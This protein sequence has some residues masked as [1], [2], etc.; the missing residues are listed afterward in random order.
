MNHHP[1][2]P[3]Q[4]WELHL[5]E[6]R[7]GGLMERRTAEYLSPAV[8]RCSLTVRAP[9]GSTLAANISDVP[10]LRLALPVGAWRADW[11]SSDWG[12]EFH[13]RQAALTDGPLHLDV[14]VGRSSKTLHPWLCLTSPEHGAVIISPA[15]SGNWSMDATPM[16]DGG[17]SVTAGINPWKF[18]R[19]VTAAK[20]F[21]A[22]QVYVA[23]GADRLAAGSELAGVIG[24]W[25]APRSAWS[26]SQPMEWNHW[27]P[28]EDAEI[29]LATFVENAHIASGL[30]FDVATCDA[31]WFGRADAATFWE[32]ERGDWDSENT[33]RFP[34]GLSGLA[35]A[36]REAGT[37]FGVWIEAEAVG[38]DA[39]ITTERPD[40]IARRD[41]DPP[42]PGHGMPD[43]DDPGWLGYI[44]LGSPAGRD[45]IRHVLDRLIS[46][47]GCRWIKWDFNLDPGAGCSRTDHGHDAGDGLYEHYRGL[48]AIVDEYRATYPDILWEACSSGGLRIDLGLVARFHAVFLSDPDWTEFHLQLLWGAAQML[49]AAS[50]LH[51][52]ESQWRTHHPHQHLDPAALDVATLDQT[53]HSVAL[54]RHAVSYKLPEFSPEL[55]DRLAAHVLTHKQHIA[56][57]IADGAVVF[58]LTPQPLRDGGGERFPAFQLATVAPGPAVISA[59]RLHGAPEQAVIRPKHL[60]PD[61]VYEVRCLGPGA[62][63]GWPTEPVGGALLMQDGMT[64]AADGPAQSWLLCLTPTTV[65][66]P[67]TEGVLP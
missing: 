59:I 9:H 22:P 66:S 45:H 47:T 52:S 24:R 41:D 40:I 15:W 30:G 13:P 27:W 2:P 10:T 12:D 16:P 25:V 48:Y 62:D 65:R 44:C 33:D 61:A 14:R 60:D 64:I 53:M 35:D 54:H 7:L 39:T 67:I 57:L 20:P 43:P 6:T 28:Y 50:M 5:G 21:V 51:F 46:R 56:P 63:P 31:G 1:P 4:A 49:P 42:S 17:L 3:V 19:N 23:W 29:N 58:P 18:S 38:V 34:T 36:A 8:A 32:K 26:Q 55:R 37:E 11:F